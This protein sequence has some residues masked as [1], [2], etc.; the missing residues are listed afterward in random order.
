MAEVVWGDE[1]GGVH[2]EAFNTLVPPD[3]YHADKGYGSAQSMT[4]IVLD[5]EYGEVD[6]KICSLNLARS[7]Q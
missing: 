1:I 4:S 5:S 7:F 6:R 2:F 3:Q